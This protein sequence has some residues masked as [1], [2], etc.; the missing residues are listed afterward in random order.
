MPPRRRR[1]GKIGGE[2]T[3]LDFLQCIPGE[4]LLRVY[5]RNISFIDHLNVSLK[6]RP[7]DLG[8]KPNTKLTNEVS[9]LHYR[10]RFLAAIPRIPAVLASLFRI[11]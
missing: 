8:E 7:K 9:L 5:P 3:D 4:T 10:S 2:L 1:G 11:P 6:I